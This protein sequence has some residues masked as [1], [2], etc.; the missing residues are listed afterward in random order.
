MNKRPLSPHLQIYHLPLSAYLSIAHRITGVVLT[1]SLPILALWLVASA[2]FSETLSF[3][4]AF[5]QS[6]LG[7]LV[8]FLWTVAL[9]HHAVHGVRHLLW[10]AG[11]GFER[12]RLLRYAQL[13]MVAVLL[14]VALIWSI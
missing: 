11:L 12:E 13:E 8:L 1:L 7:K 6:S 10:D 5:W 4:A 14:V 3:I 9:A 2:W